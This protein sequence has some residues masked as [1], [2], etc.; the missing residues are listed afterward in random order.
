MNE[1]QTRH[2]IDPQLSES[3]ALRMG[4]QS[5][6]ANSRTAARSNYGTYDGRNVGAIVGE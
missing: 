2:P 6:V 3:I 4:N 5:E 1:N